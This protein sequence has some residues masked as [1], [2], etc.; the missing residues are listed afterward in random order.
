MK[1]AQLTNK[2][3]STLINKTLE[4]NYLGEKKKQNKTTTTSRGIFIVL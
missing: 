2:K 3:E 4:E 1:I